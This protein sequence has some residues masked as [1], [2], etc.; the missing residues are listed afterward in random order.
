M[1]TNEFEI[2][3]HQVS[4]TLE[5]LGIHH[6]IVGSVA[7]SKYGENRATND[8]DIVIMLKK[9]QIDNLVQAMKTE[10]YIDQ[11]MIIEALERNSS[12][13]LVH[14]ETGIKIDFFTQ[15]ARE[16]DRVALQRRI[17]TIP[18][19]MRIEDVLLG[20]FEWYKATDCT[21]EKQWRDILGLLRFNPDMNLEYATHWAAEIG[22]LDLLEQ[23]Q[24]AI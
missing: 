8:I 23:A 3:I 6:G 18:A 11:E 24:K 7:S 16:Y 12:F 21:S 1:S 17:T 19:F 20:K 14:L 4:D 10:F 15:K 2:L 22:V 9:N 13:N 5:Q